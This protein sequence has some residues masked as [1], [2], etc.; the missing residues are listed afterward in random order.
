VLLLGATACTGGPKLAEV[1]PLFQQDAQ[2]LID[3]L[4]DRRGT[5][6]SKPTVK[7]DAR[8]DV[9]CGDGKAK[10]VF[11]ASVPLKLGSSLDNTF[12]AAMDT[13]VAELVSIG[14]SIKTAPDSDDLTRWEMVVGAHFDDN[15]AAMHVVVTAAP[16]LVATLTG[17]TNCLDAG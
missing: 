17:E 8:T 12:D 9:S 5:D 16:S 4:A 14:Y 2:A 13:V 7:Q 6:G 3:K 1:G 11:E 10:R 15:P